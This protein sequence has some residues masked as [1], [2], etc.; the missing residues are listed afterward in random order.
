MQEPGSGTAKE[1]RLTKLAIP[2]AVCPAHRPA[3]R[4]RGAPQHSRIPVRVVEWAE[5]RLH[6]PLL[7]AKGPKGCAHRMAAAR[8]QQCKR[9]LCPGTEPVRPWRAAGVRKSLRLEASRPG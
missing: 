6:L 8:S 1:G 3:A 4:V 2:V 9:L 7:G 5:N